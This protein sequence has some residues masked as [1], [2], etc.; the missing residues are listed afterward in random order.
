[1][2]EPANRTNAGKLRV[3]ALDESGKPAAHVHVDLI[4]GAGGNTKSSA[5]ETEIVRSLTTSRQGFAIFNLRNI[6]VK[7]RSAGLR[8]RFAGRAELSF[9]LPD[10]LFDAGGHYRAYRL[11]ANLCAAEKPGP[12][13]DDALEPDDIWALPEIFPD[14]GDLEFGDDYCGRLVPNDL[15]VRSFNHHQVVRTKKNVIT[16]LATHDQN[17]ALHEGEVIE[18]QTTASR[19]GYTFGELLYS[20]PLAPCE[21]VTLAVSHWEQRQSARAEQQSTS[22][23]KRN[24]TYYRRNG[25]SEALSAASKQ[26]HFG[27]AV[28][29]GGA[30]GSGSSASGFIYGI[31]MKATQALQASVGATVSGSFDRKEF[32]SHATRELSDAIEQ[33]AEAFR[34]DH[35]VVIMEQAESED[36]TVSYRTVC[37]NNHCHVLN[38]FYHEVL[39]NFRIST[40]MLGHR[41]VYFVPYQVRDFDAHLALCA[42]PFLLPF[43]L[44]ASIVDCYRKLKPA[45]AKATAPAKTITDEFKIDVSIASGMV[46][47]NDFKLIV[48]TKNGAMQFFSIAAT[49]VWQTGQSFSYVVNTTNFDVN[50]LHAVGLMKGLA[51]GITGNLVL[52]S[53]TI[54]V[55][56]PVNGQWVALGSGSTTIWTGPVG[57]SIV[58]ASYKPPATTQPAATA[59]NDEACLYQ[60]LEHLNCNKVYYN[61]LL[62][63]F[64][65]PN[66]RICRFDRIICSADGVSLADLVIPEPL[67]VFGCSVAFAKA[68]SP[69]VPYTDEPIVSE[70]LLTLPTPG[71]FADAA[72]GQCSACEKIDKSVYWNWKDSPCMCA[73]KDVT[74][75]T[76]AETPLIQAGQSPFPVLPTAV[77]ATG[78]APPSGE[79]AVTNSLVSAFG[80]AMAT[81][82]LASQ[83]SEKELA[84]L[85]ALLTKMVETLKDLI[86]SDSG[87][88]TTTDSGDD[89][90]AD[91]GEDDDNDE[92]EDEGGS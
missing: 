79:A 91:D 90:D 49:G 56:D 76:P 15:T 39:N 8:V 52:S 80:S 68:S 37:N 45:A 43:L 83:G 60:V 21:S 2:V 87:S 85:Q 66:E 27:W 44:D 18:Y 57:Q 67:A 19:L 26:S 41:E 89:T 36:H 73:G 47:S 42:K 92:G 33:A 59:V 31:L 11:P 16:C 20:L 48:Q 38:I 58:P 35:Q 55:K 75:K 69:Y 88:T 50:D 86:P 10:Q 81:A 29:A 4:V 53:F 84:A 9:D 77:W 23:E 40:R 72:L 82:L 1:V 22:L 78:V 63:L 74:L 25:L 54:S 32:A 64:E 70:R 5:H 3:R 62:W 12:W 46:P 13:L 17:I 28:S 7:L 61:S 24:S 14:L 30:S 71:I 65:D 51:T 34:S 6:P